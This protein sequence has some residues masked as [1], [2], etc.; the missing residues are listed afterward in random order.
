MTEL[1]ELIDTVAADDLSA[2]LASQEGGVDGVLDR[3]FG[4]I[5]ATFDAAKAGVEE[6]VFRFDV[7]TAEGTKTR[8]V[9]VAVG[10]CSA[11]VTSDPEATVTLTLDIADF[12]AL[13]TGRLTGSEAYM[14]GKL[15]A[16]GD[17][18]FAMNWSEWFGT[19]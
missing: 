7:V 14:S 2:A 18:F 8:Y 17:V 12:L 1:G 16:A 19:L 4:G 3:V 10:K 11:S 9:T 5:I 13:A 6:G 15:E